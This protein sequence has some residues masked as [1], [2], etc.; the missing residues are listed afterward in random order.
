MKLYIN[1]NLDPYFNLAAEEYLIR[2]TD[3]DIAMLWR[4]SPAVIIGKNQNAFCEVD[5]DFT[6][7]HDIAV[8]RRLT[9]GGAVF[10][11]PGN[12]NFTFISPPH[13]ALSE[14]IQ[15]GGLDFAHFCAPILD[16]LRAIG[17]DASLSGRNDIVADG[18]KISGNAQ[19]VLDGVTMHHGTLLFSAELAR[20]QG[21]LRADPAKLHS[22]GIASVRSRVANIADLQSK[23]T[24]AEEF[25]ACLT[26]ALEQRYSVTAERF[27]DD[28]TA[29]IRALAEEKYASDAWNL[30]RMGTFDMTRRKRFPYGSVE[31]SLTVKNGRMEEIRITGDFFGVRD[32]SGLAE[33]LRGTAYRRE[34]AAQKL[35]EIPVGDYIFGAESADLLAILF[36]SDVVL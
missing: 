20:M 25:L 8:V 13:G 11:D 16:A 31:I 2:H 5:L 36:D 17:V 14:G 24:G 27:T 28:M 22:K 21:A 1:E 26:Y 33:Q 34:A 4:N 9:G 35:A 10:H 7:T 15:A 6:R 3:D 30:D 12:I 23:V 32:A 29:Q 18:R 19:C